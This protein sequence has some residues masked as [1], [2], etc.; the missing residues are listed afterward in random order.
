MVSFL[1]KVHIL[2]LVFRGSST[3]NS[4]SLVPGLIAQCL[5]GFSLVKNT[6]KLVSFDR[7][8]DD[9]ECIHGIRTLNAIMLLISHK[10]MALFF[11]PYINR[12]QMASVSIYL[13]VLNSSVAKIKINEKVP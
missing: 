1:P 12:T 8:P 4:F 2:V 5:M 3:K 6:K 7:A 11:N 10:S 13:K 9:I